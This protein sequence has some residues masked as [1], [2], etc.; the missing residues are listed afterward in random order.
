MHTRDLEGFDTDIFPDAVRNVNNVVARRDLSKMANAVACG[1]HAVQLCF[2]PS[3]NVLFREDSN[4]RC[5][6]LK[7]R[8]QCP[9]C[10]A[11]CAILRIPFFAQDDRREIPSGEHLADQIRPFSAACEHQY[12][13]FIRKIAAQFALEQGKLPLKRRHRHHLKANESRRRTGRNRAVH[14]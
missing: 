13:R 3:E 9:G 7:A 6:Q 11:D 4:M 12:A 8:A 14:Q 2:M 5:A 1:C 10:N